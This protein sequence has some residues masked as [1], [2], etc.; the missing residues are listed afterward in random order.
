MDKLTQ[1]EYI[2]QLPGTHFVACCHNTT[3]EA[4]LEHM[5]THKTELL[6]TLYKVDRVQ[7]RS[8]DMVMHYSGKAGKEKDGKS[9]RQFAGKNTYSNYDGL[10]VHENLQEGHS[11]IFLNK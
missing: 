11:A 1:K 2:E 7:L 4:I 6:P 5:A 9:Y 10:L 8:K 3:I